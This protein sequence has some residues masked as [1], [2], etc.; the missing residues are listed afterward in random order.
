[1]QVTKLVLCDVHLSIATRHDVRSAQRG[2]VQK[3]GARARSIE[4]TEAHNPALPEVQ[5][6]LNQISNVGLLRGR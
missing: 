6:P 3:Q 5:R 4:T 2:D 1:M